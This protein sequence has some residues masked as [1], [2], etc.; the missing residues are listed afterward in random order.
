MSYDVGTL[1][2]TICL[3]GSGHGYNGSVLNHVDERWLVYRRNCSPLCSVGDD[4]IEY[5][6]ITSDFDLVGSPQKL[7]ISGQ[8]WEDPRG[9][10]LNNKAVLFVGGP[11]GA[12]SDWKSRTIYRINCE[13]EKSRIVP[14]VPMP[15]SPPSSMVRSE[16][17]WIP[18]LPSDSCEL[19]LL[20]SLSPLKVL[21]YI[22]DNS[23]VWAESVG[24]FSD[25]ANRAVSCS[26]QP[27]EV[28][29]G[30]YLVLNH[31][32]EFPFYPL[33]QCKGRF[34][35]KL[36]HTRLYYVSASLFSFDGI[37]KAEKQSQDYLVYETMY[38]SVNERVDRPEYVVFP[39]YI[40][41]RDDRLVVLLS[42]N[43][44]VMKVVSFDLHKLIDSL[45]SVPSKGTPFV[46]DRIVPCPI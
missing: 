6:S 24:G 32:V 1:L 25:P 34:Q 5:V 20:Y 33:S 44:N 31:S 30:K 10:L 3:S 12:P 40:E 46:H 4:T 41:I 45:V 13:L 37:F 16:K 2:K 21:R 19:H 26:T 7:Q 14:S 9:I 35:K 11:K 22:N 23:L 17:N 28:A 43:D 36:S 8:H 29:P 42:E 27:V 38:E 18:F 15:L 39:T